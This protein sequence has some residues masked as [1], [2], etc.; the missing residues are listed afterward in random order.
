MLFSIFLNIIK[1]DEIKFYPLTLGL[2][3]SALAPAASLTQE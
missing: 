1:T 3:L 2:L